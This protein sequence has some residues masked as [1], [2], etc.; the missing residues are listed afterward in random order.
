[1]RWAL[2]ATIVGLGL[3]LSFDVYRYAS[4]TFEYASIQ[5]ESREILVEMFPDSDN[6]PEGKER[7]FVQQAINRGQVNSV[8]L[9][10]FQPLIAT[11]S[12]VFKRNNIQVESITFADNNLVVACKLNNLSQVDQIDR[13][14]N[15][16]RNVS[17]ELLSS[18]VNDGSVTARYKVSG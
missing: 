14:I 18:N 1:L 17:S 10:E 5:Q 8:D 15:Q 11:V 6:V 3:K 12:K 7:F 13:Q 9:S 16:I 4:Y 2:V